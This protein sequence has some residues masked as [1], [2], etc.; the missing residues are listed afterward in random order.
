VRKLLGIS[1]LGLVMMANT[2]CAGMAARRVLSEV[3]GASSKTKAVP[4]TSTARF[5]QFQG[6]KINAPHTDLGGLVNSR[7]SSALPGA[8]RESLTTGKNAPFPGGSPTLDIDPEI[9]FYNDP[10]G[11]G[12]LFGGDSY[13]VVLFT[14]S[15]DGAA[16]G[17][18]QVVTKTAAARTGPDDMA[19]SMAKSLGDFFDQNIKKSKPKKSD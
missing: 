17:K 6:V 4:G 8:L 3:A 18:V 16:L 2:G 9:T 7:F 10:G 12:D 15:A 13:A 5:S 14:L 19:K 1:I 11:M